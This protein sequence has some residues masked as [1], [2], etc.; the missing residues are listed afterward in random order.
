MPHNELI[1]RLKLAF[2]ASLSN[3]NAI[4]KWLD[5]DSMDEMIS[6]AWIGFEEPAR[7]ALDHTPSISDPMHEAH[8]ASVKVRKVLPRPISGDDVER[9]KRALAED[10]LRCSELGM[11][12][13]SDEWFESNARAAIAS[14]SPSDVE[15]DEGREKHFKPGDRPN[16]VAECHMMLDLVEAWAGRLESQLAA[17]E[18]LTTPTA[19]LEPLVLPEEG[20][21]LG[22]PLRGQPA[23]HEPDPSGSGPAGEC[24][25]QEGGQ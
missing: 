9:V 4:K 19:S 16:T 2:W 10:D 1:E 11:E 15:R 14:M 21:G 7:Q 22:D 6:A 18:L 17:V 20:E 24:Q 12:P 8:I 13:A 25:A 3:A 23:T 5:H